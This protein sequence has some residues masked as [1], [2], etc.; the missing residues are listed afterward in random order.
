MQNVTLKIWTNDR[1]NVV[2]YFVKWSITVQL[3]S[4]LTGLGS[5]VLLMLNKI[6]IYKFG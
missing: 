5:A 4:C 6:Q 3:T 1:V 2:A